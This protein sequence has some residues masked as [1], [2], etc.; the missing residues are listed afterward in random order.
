MNI[1]RGLQSTRW[2][3]L[4]L[5][6]GG[7]L[8]AALWIV[9]TNVHGPTSFNLDRAVLGRSMQFWGSLLGGPPN[10]LVALGL[11]MLY[12]RLAKNARRLIRVGYTLT[13]I[14][15]IVPAIIDLLMGAL[16]APFFIPVAALGLIML[17]LGSWPSPRLQR[18]SLYLLMSIGTLLAI[19][20]AWAL[21]PLEVSDSIGG[22]RLYGLLAHFLPGI[23][24]ALLGVSF[25]TTKAPAA[26]EPAPN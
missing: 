15:L 19:A 10:L 24:W 5:V 11:L 8:M 22:Y 2:A 21:V 20:F 17:A 13:L 7:V 6:S 3:A 12:P 16:G 9:F 1:D 25:W 23:G 26:L 4:A 18:P 14:G